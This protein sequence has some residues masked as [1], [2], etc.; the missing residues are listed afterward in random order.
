MTA[1]T[2]I[3]PRRALA[4]VGISFALGAVTYFAVQ[5]R[6]HPV[7]GLLVAWDVASLV[8]L[9][10]SWVVIGPAD[11][12]ATRR[13]AGSEDP[14]RTLVYVT[15][16]LK[17]SASLV[18]ATIIA[19]IALIPPARR[20]PLDRHALLVRRGD[21]L[22]ADAHRFHLPVR[23]RLY[24][25]EDSEGVGGVELPKGPRTDVLRFRVLRVHHRH[26]LSGV[27]HLRYQPSDSPCRAAARAH[28]LHL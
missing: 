13:L 9:A 17:S 15:V 28:Q 20:G 7:A 1:H 26:V 23:A 25:R 18:A 2:R 14:G 11:A 27:G 8:L 19:R 4:R 10:L 6:I 5:A 22:D 16:V 24:Y 12:G 3:D 21:G